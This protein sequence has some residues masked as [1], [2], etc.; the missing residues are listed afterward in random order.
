MLLKK[1]IF[2][3]VLGLM[4][5]SLAYS[6]PL[7]AQPAPNPF[8]SVTEEQLTAEG[9]ITAADLDYFLKFLAASNDII[10]KMDEDPSLNFEEEIAK[11]AKD[12]NV[13]TVRTRYLMEKV[14]YAIFVATVK[15][16]QKA[17]KAPVK[18][19]ELTPAESQIIQDNL[20][21]FRFF[22]E[23]LNQ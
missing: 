16:P 12:N 1:F 8:E 21:K 3:S 5:F 2:F 6:A 14:P 17:P 11:F 10:Q 20:E 23:S 9:P 19:M 18:Y 7:K 22:T 4:A 15:D 13:T